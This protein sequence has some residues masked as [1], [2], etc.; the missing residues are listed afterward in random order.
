M[1]LQIDLFDQNGMLEITAAYFL[2]N[3][4]YGFMLEE[5]ML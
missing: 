3:R 2:K 1:N 5:N 4:F